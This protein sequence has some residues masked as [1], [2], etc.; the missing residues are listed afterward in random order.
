MGLKN[1]KLP[2]GSGTDAPAV[3]EEP[4][5]VAVSSGSRAPSPNAPFRPPAVTHPAASPARPT[6]RTSLLPADNPQPPP[7][8]R[9]DAP[10]NPA[11]AKPPA[12]PAP[13]PQ[14]ADAQRN[15]EQR[16]RHADQPPPRKP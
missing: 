16:L 11:A 7:P 2:A 14:P 1:L 4:Q 12:K 3:P 6:A 13:A 8:P 15:L 9:G 10:P 5:P